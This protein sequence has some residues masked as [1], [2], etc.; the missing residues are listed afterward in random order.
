MTRELD[1]L[2]GLL[3]ARHSVRAFRPDP[4]PWAVLERVLSAAQTTPSWCNTQP[5]HVHLLSGRATSGFAAALAAYAS[6]NTP[7]PDLAIP[8][9]YTGVNSDRR[10]ASRA[11]LYAALG[12]KSQDHAAR[13][14]QLLENCRFFGAPHVGIV[15]TDAELSAYGAVDAGAYVSI[16]LLAA[17]AA[18]L[19]AI[20]Q[21]SI[22]MYAQFVR[23][24]LGL[25]ATRLIVCGVAIGYE[26]KRH[27]VNAFRTERASVDRAVTLVGEPHG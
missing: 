6:R 23:D 3:K 10:R 12:I 21:A 9:N 16:L 14:A 20:A 26:D 4:V 27:P 13:E 19:G 8:R 7:S 15:S 25:P 22:A 1:V 11:A 18:R 24:Y 2:H 17:E 5:W